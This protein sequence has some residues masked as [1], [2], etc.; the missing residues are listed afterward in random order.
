[1]RERVTAKLP[2]LACDNTLRHKTLRMKKPL[3]LDCGSCEVRM[4]A[5]ETV[6]LRTYNTARH[7]QLNG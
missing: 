2:W 1:M 5:E 4:K 7:N 3:S 6:D